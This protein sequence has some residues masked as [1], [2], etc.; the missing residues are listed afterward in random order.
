M[1]HVYH[2]PVK[3]YKR[4]ILCVEEYIKKGDVDV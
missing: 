3:R 2:L 1:Y 4:I